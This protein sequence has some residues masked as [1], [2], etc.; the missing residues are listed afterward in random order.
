MG[1]G[2]GHDR[3]RTPRVALLANTTWYLY[4]FRLNLMRTL[5]E[6]G[7]NVV[8]LAPPDGYEKQVEAEGIRHRSTWLG[9]GGMNPFVEVK[10]VG[11]LVHVLRRERPDVLLTFTPKGN[12]YGG[13]A[14]R[15]L[16]IGLVP[17]VS[18]LGEAFTTKRALTLLV[19]PL[20][21][22]A[23]R[24]A[25]WVFFQNNDDMS[26]FV[27]RGLCR[28]QIVERIPGSGVDVR[29][30]VADPAMDERRRASD[31]RLVFL[32]VARMIHEKGIVEF[33]EAARI[34]RSMGLPAVFRLI[35]PLVE[36]RASAI[37]RSQLTSWCD[38][39]V[40]EY[41]GATDDVKAAIQQADC[42]V[43]P[44]YY[45]EGV[46][47]SLLEGASMARPVIASDMPGCRDVVDDGVTG[48][49]CAARDAMDLGQ[50]MQQFLRL[51]PKERVAMGR[52]G[53]DKMTCQF[54]E[55]YVLKRYVTILAGQGRLA[56]TQS[57]P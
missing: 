49:L 10:A 2:S 21:R 9:G 39:G 52:A 14:S 41:G 6:V 30:F 51:T 26:M 32:L 34:L 28:P 48:Y 3:P 18:G 22:V 8:A 53:R 33:V 55:Q 47:R 43:L 50:K 44:S 23:F 27:D 19:K 5:R 38:E 13:L 54:D 36:G 24:N 11:H 17:N 56:R 7:A 57:G 40:V 20:Y 46:P 25:L 15:A 4:N 37:T 1:E 35:G 29:W 42:V 31:T 45:R 12:I 16:G